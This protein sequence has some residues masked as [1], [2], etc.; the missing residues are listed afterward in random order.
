[1]IYAFTVTSKQ[2]LTICP[3][4]NFNS[5]K[6]MLFVLLSLHPPFE[7]NLWLEKEI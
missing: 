3:L 6:M 7:K 5:R 4:L 2:T 1:M